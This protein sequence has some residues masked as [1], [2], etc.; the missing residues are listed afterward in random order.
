MD[1]L[2][3]EPGSSNDSCLTSTLDGNEVIGIEAES[4][5]D[6]SEMLRT[7]ILCYVHIWLLLYQGVL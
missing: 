1:V 2:N 3:G 5:S 6:I 4:V 7:F